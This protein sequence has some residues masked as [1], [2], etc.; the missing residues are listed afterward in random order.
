MI[1][2]RNEQR[3]GSEQN[4]KGIDKMYLNFLGDFDGF[5]KKVRTFASV[6]LLPGEEV[7]FHVHT[8]EMESY[9][10]ISGVGEYNDNGTIVPA[11]AGMVTFTPSGE[12]HG[13]KNTG[14]ERLEFI[15]LIVLD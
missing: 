13:I 5:N 1:K 9:Y 12:G 3:V 2:Y 7:E 10:I 8:G 6:S 15:A 4:S 11:E 14:S